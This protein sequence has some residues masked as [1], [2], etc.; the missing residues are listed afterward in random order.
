MRTNKKPFRILMTT[1]LSGEGVAGELVEG[2]DFL[3][4]DRRVGKFGSFLL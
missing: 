2:S 3:V 4:S 1:T